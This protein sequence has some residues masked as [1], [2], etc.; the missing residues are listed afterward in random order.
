[1]QKDLQK[2]F[3]FHSS[4]EKRVISIWRVIVTEAE[5]ANKIKI[6]D[7]AAF[8]WPESLS[9]NGAA[10][11]KQIVSFKNFSIL[12]LA[13]ALITSGKFLDEVIPGRSK[14]FLGVRDETML[15]FKVDV[16]LEADFENL[17][18]VRVALRKHGLDLVKGEMEADCIV[19]KD[20][21]PIGNSVE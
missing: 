14:Q 19:I 16:N 12:E 7:E 1:L 21:Q 2:V 9:G 11:G 15:D 8:E 6:K 17:N 3:N 5:L 20:A 10:M 4:V 13:N 18:S